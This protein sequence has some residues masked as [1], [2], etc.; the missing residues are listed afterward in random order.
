MA[1]NV[2]GKEPIVSETF[3]VSTLAVMLT[4]LVLVAGCAKERTKTASRTQVSA[5][6]ESTHADA[7]TTA[8]APDTATAKNSYKSSD[9]PKAVYT[10]SD[11]PGRGSY[12]K[13]D[14]TGLTPDQLNRVIHRLRSEDCTCGCQGDLI[15]EC[16]VNDPQ[17][18]A[19]VTLTK[20]II[21]EEKAKS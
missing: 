20:Q 17:C 6:S 19:A 1:G 8:A 7:E 4:A 21:R 13:V 10:A 14:F 15:D 16:L 5:Q 18:T 11:L 3:R 12:L 2:P 9:D